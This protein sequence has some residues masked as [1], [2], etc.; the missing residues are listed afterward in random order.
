[1]G[2]GWAAPSRGARRALSGRSGHDADSVRR[3][4][5]LTDLRQQ[6]LNR[7]GTGQ[8]QQHPVFILLDSCGN[9]EQREDDCFR[10][11][12]CQRG[13]L[14]PQLAQLLAHDAC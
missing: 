7:T 9:L 8:V 6:R 2:Q 4:E 3:V 13:S 5:P 12:V 14:Q 1:M 11:G 10:L